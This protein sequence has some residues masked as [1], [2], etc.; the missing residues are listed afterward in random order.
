M[1]A[2]EVLHEERVQSRALSGRSQSV[3][4]FSLGIV[5]NSTSQIFGR[6]GI[7]RFRYILG[8]HSGKVREAWMKYR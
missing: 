7:I 6:H 8:L 1:Q 2:A 3:A 5:T 4:I